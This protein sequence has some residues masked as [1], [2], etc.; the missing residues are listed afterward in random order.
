MTIWIPDIAGKGP[1]YLAIADAIAEDI[2]NG[3]LE[4]GARLP[5]HRDLAWRIGVTVGTVTRAYGEARR[6]GLVQGEVGRGTFVS[7]PPVLG[8]SLPLTPP[9]DG[10]IDLAVNYQVVDDEQAVLARILADISRG[11]DLGPLLRYQPA[12]G[13]LAHRRAAADWLRLGG[14]DAQPENIVIAAG[15]QHAIDLVFATIAQPGDLILAEALTYAGAKGAAEARRLRLQGVAM[16]EQ[17]L[18]PDA[19]EAACRSGAPKALYCMTRLHNP[20]VCTLPRERREAIV[21]I[22]ERHNVILIEDDLYGFLLDDPAPPLASLAPHRTYYINSLSKC[23]APGLRV[24][25][26]LAPPDAA[27]A[28]TGM[29]RATIYLAMP[30]A[31]EIAT[32]LINEGTTHQLARKRRDEA[33]ARQHILA[34][35]LSGYDFRPS[36]A[37]FHT[38]LTLPPPWRA[39]DF[40]AHVRQRGAAITPAEAFVVGRAPAP[41]AVRVCLGGT[42]TRAELDRGLAILRRLLEEGPGADTMV[43]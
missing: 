7:T 40:A 16:D 27:P 41:H 38:W 13:I 14:V 4:V 24:G 29:L 3:R 28:I 12:A 25:Y 39:N 5:A 22:A 17:G 33:T 20:A 26:V 21:E 9:G 18:L 2:A 10:L 31:G 15:G 37:G 36:T 6:R 32:R 8:S 30:L 19:F 35:H 42:G 23:F 11:P 43:V 34:E 1:R